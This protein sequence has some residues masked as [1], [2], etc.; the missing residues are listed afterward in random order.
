MKL[1]RW[2]VVLSLWT[3]LQ[4]GPAH[5][6]RYN[7][8][9]VGFVDLETEPYHLYGFVHPDLPA[10]TVA[11]FK[12]LTAAALRDSNV[13]VELVTADEQKP[14]PALKYWPAHASR[15]LPT[16]VLVSPDGQSLPLT[17][18]QPGEPFPQTLSSAMQAVV[19]SPQRE[20]ILR[21]VSQTFASVLLIEGESAPENSRARQ[22]IAEAIDQIRA[23][24]KW[25]PKTIAR[26]PVLLVLDAASLEREEILLWSLRQNTAKMSQPRAAVLYGKARWIG[27]V[28]KGAEITARNLTGVLSI[29]GADCECGLD[30]SWT[31]GTRLPVRWDPK[32]HAQVAKSLEFDPENPMVKIEASRILGRRGS[33]AGGT[34]ASVG[35]QEIPLETGPESNRADATNEN[36]TNRVQ[37]AAP[38][39]GTPPADFVL[40][41]SA[42]VLKPS[43]ILL[44]GLA[45]LIISA[46]LWIVRA[47]AKK[48]NL[49]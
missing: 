8:R 25:M 44:A 45:G 39:G 2:A 31:Q 13:L 46:G 6:C 10:E 37:S 40:G 48:K 20:E 14:H 26:P 36:D 34:A 18:S 30:I 42:P 12:E 19:S 11:Q 22:V 7:V 15:S 17:I 27:P 1:I 5:A 35:Y 23:Q 32:L 29:I 28:M 49:R 41:V 3:C 21:A 43:L 9:D 47:A 38:R 16:A 33:A 24:M 4:P